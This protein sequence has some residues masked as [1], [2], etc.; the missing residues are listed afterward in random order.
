M[1]EQFRKGNPT[2]REAIYHSYSNHT[3]Y[4]NNWDL[5]DLSASQIIGGYLEHL[6]HTPLDQLAQ[7]T[8]LWEQRIS[9]VATLQWIRNGKFDD[10]LRLA[11]MLLLHEHDLIRKAVGWMLREVGKRDKKLLCQF[12]DCR[13]KR[14]PR[15]MLRYAIEHFSPE[16]RQYYM[17][18]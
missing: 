8:H 12:L 2:K 15:T 5:V 10:T 14:M 17:Q 18:R 7:S 16:E 6:D 13:H 9:I 4:I 1:D 3:H 11:D